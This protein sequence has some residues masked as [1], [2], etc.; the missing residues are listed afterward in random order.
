[1]ESIPWTWILWGIV[2]LIAIKSLTSMSEK[3]K[4]RLQGLLK[5]YIDQQKMEAQK[6][7]KI[8]GLQAKIRKLKLEA[9]EQAEQTLQEVGE[10]RRNAA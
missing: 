5:Q 9:E 3:L 4:T 6:R 1:M 10:K 8:R 7:A 2:V